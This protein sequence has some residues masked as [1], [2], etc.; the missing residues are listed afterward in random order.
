V[1]AALDAATPAVAVIDSIQSL[2]DVDTG[3]TPGSVAQVRACAQRLV[4]EA[5]QRDVAIVIVGHVTKEGGLAGPRALEHMVDTVLAFD[6]DR[7]QGLRILRATKH[8]YGPTGGV[9]LL[10]MA[11]D[12]LRAVDDASGYLLAGRH[13]APGSVV[14]PALDGSRVLTVEVQALVAPRTLA[15]PQRRA[16]GL[17]SGRLGLVLAVLDQRGGVGITGS[18]VWAAAVGG[19]RITEAGA[20]LGVAMAVASAATG[21]PVPID[22]AVCGEVGLSGEVRHV[23]QLPARIGEAARLGFRRLVVP[24]SAPEPRSDVELVRVASVL[25][26]LHALR[27]LPPTPPPWADAGP[28]DHARPPQEA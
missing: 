5:K 6:G 22:V 13:H 12:G 23:A 4:V 20:D 24:E 15:Q 16:A 3:G 7:H 10:E 27:L 19:V 14:V 21:R 9:G 8:R 2:T 1:V 26:A 28:R 11:P 17:D 18:D 25:D